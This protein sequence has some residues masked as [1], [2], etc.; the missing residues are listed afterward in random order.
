MGGIR[1]QSSQGISF[2]W[3]IIFIFCH[4]DHGAQAHLGP[5]QGM[6][7]ASMSVFVICKRIDIVDYA[8]YVL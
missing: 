1:L 2:I 6:L 3:A 4:H 8:N 7:N 5:C